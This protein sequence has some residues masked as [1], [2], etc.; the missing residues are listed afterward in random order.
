MT[1]M[2]L[3]KTNWDIIEKESP[4]SFK[5]FMD[6]IDDFKASCNWNELFNQGKFSLST[7]EIDEGF[8]K[9]KFIYAYCPKFHEIPFAMQ[10][11]I[12]ENFFLL[13]NIN[14]YPLRIE[15]KQTWSFHTVDFIEGKILTKTVSQD[16]PHPFEY[17]F[18]E[19][20]EVAAISVA[21]KMLN[22]GYIKNL[23]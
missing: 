7:E 6:Y 18:A 21:F 3:D 19:E 23:N 10:K 13:E 20:A 8:Q 2:M 22:D 15:G 4:N 1:I 14:Y 17:N 9:Q 12:I 5:K 11:G 16:S